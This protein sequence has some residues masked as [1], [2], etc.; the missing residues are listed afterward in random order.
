MLPLRVCY[1]EE[2]IHGNFASLF[3]KGFCATQDDFFQRFPES[4]VT[5]TESRP[6]A[7]RPT[8]LHSHWVAQAN[9]AGRSDRHVRGPLVAVLL[10]FA[11]RVERFL[12]P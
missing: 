5:A 1:P 11:P 4:L 7:V 6:T 8:E 12:R 10:P 3:A 2:G 9:T